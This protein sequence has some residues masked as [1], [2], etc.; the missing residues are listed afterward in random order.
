MVYSSRYCAQAELL[1][2]K[3]S[4]TAG[5]LA[6]PTVSAMSAGMTITITT[7]FGVTNPARCMV[8]PAAA[9]A[10]S[11][12]HVFAAT[13][14]HGSPPGATA[15]GTTAY[16]VANYAGLLPTTSYKAYCAQTAATDVRGVS[17]AFT[18][19]ISS[20]TA[21]SAVTGTVV[22]LTTT[23]AGTGSA[24]CVVLTATTNAPTT[25]QVIAP[26]GGAAAEP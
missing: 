1:S 4:F 26:T 21:S 2:D 19:G 20:Q 6:Q 14:A 9:S 16:A 12:A 23:F 15:S 7:T 24:R 5:V 17:A 25:V 22:V 8:V 10:P 18:P 13:G 3:V 11:A